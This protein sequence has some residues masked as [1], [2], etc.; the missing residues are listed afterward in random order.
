MSQVA[1]R[2]S[3]RPWLVL[4]GAVLAAWLL[5][6]NRALAQVDTGTIRG[7][8]ADSSGRPVPEAQVAITNQ[9]TGLVMG[10]KTSL[11]GTYIFT[12]LR[13]GA[14]SL[15]VTMAGFEKQTKDG[16]RLDVQQNAVVD[17]A[18]KPGQVTTSVDVTAASPL[19]QT[20]DASVG[21]V[22]PTPPT[23]SSASCR[24]RRR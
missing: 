12:P 15:T 21:Q 13:A 4:A 18:L 2:I 3:N 17:F 8:V 7:M 11:D 9:G 24:R 5:V 22:F 1:K 20:Q 6:P 16:I 19:L 10:T 14:Y 23:N